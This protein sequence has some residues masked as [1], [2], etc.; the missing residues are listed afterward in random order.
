M[1]VDTGFSEHP[2]KNLRLYNFSLGLALCLGWY[3]YGMMV[4]VIFVQEMTTLFCGDNKMWRLLRVQLLEWITHKIYW[5]DISAWIPRCLMFAC[6]LK[7]VLL[8][9]V[10]VGPGFYFF[11]LTA[12][13]WDSSCR[14]Q[15]FFYGF[16]LMFHRHYYY[17]INV[18]CLFGCLLMIR[19]WWKK[20]Q[21]SAFSSTVYCNLRFLSLNIFLKYPI[22]IYKVKK[23]K[24]SELLQ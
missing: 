1:I 19:S 7:G 4:P 11:S 17:H 12:S 10:V 16:L 18:S 21:R 9:F 24:E 20:R 3:D 23:D 22:I 6:F 13:T 15:W 5:F 14:F 8:E 2:A